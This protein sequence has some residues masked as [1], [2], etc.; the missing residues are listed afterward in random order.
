MP[1]RP[2]IH[3]LALAPPRLAPLWQ[4]ALGLQPA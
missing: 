1:D 3:W 2:S 4:E